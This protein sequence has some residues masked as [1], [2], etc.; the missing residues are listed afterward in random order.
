MM[1]FG[2]I[3]FNT[4]KEYEKGDFILFGRYCPLGS[5]GCIDNVW[6]NI[7]AA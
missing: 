2:S 5:N 6:C 7:H 3:L 1:N 4:T